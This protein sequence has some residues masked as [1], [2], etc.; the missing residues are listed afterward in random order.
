MH[1]SRNIHTQTNQIVGMFGC[2]PLDSIFW[3]KIFYHISTQFPMQTREKIVQRITKST[4]YY[5][6]IHSNDASK[7]SYCSTSSNVRAAYT[8]TKITDGKF[9]F[10]KCKC[11][12][13]SLCVVCSSNGGV[14]WEKE[15]EREIKERA[16]F[17][18]NHCVLCELM[19]LKFIFS[20][21]SH[22]HNEIDSSNQWCDV[23]S[24]FGMLRE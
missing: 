14:K 4:N 9:R 13:F 16:L 3:F 8:L 6:H 21:P 11:G 15:R 24:I 10:F 19:K 18:E 5:L 20:F 12:N 22:T 7:R 2:A 23:L 1:G 17:L